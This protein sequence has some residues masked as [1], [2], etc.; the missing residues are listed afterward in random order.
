MRGST[1]VGRRRGTNEPRGPVILEHTKLSGSF[2]AEQLREVQG[3]VVC[4]H[5]NISRSTCSQKPTHG[6]RCSATPR[7]GTQH[8]GSWTNAA[9]LSA[10]CSLPGDSAQVSKSL[11]KAGPTSAIMSVVVVERPC[12][13]KAW[14]LHCLVREHAPMAARRR[15]LDLEG[16]ERQT[17]APRLR[18]MGIC[19]TREG[20][21]RPENVGSRHPHQM[22]TGL[23]FHVYTRRAGAPCLPVCHHPMASH[24]FTGGG[25]SRPRTPRP[26]TGGHHC[27]TTGVENRG[28]RSKSTPALGSLPRD[29]DVSRG[30]ALNVWAT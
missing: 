19:S 7:P 24:G 4:C 10:C 17:A 9:S 18:F 29:T 22:P 30:Y 16:D 26:S 25:G 11:W 21:R 2:P 28:P 8:V 3:Y 13:W 27:P 6:P 23:C 12:F 5:C 1:W 14:W 20:Y 15:G